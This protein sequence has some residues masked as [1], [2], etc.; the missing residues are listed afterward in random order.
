MQRKCFSFYYLFVMHFVDLHKVSRM[1]H[2]YIF[3]VFHK[4]TIVHDCD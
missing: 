1:V 3:V 2:L 4:S